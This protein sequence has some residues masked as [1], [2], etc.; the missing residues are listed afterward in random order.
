MWQAQTR[1]P[2]AT[3]LTW[4]LNTFAHDKI[5]PQCWLKEKKDIVSLWKLSGPY[6]FIV[7]FP[8]PKMFCTKFGSWEDDFW[9]LS[10]NFH[11]YLPLKKGMALHF[12]KRDF[13]LPKD[14]L[15]QVWLKLS[16]WLF[17]RRFL[18]LVIVLSLFPYY[19]PLEKGGALNLN[20]LEF[21]FPKNA[22]CQVWLKLVLWFLRTWFLKFVNVFSLLVLM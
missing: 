18:K 15:C 10:I 6:S 20:K 22:L 19:L 9:S 3:S 13:P 12:K 21:P 2:W 7:K 1:G 4:E 11:Y 8:S 5:R 16:L 17:I 14:A